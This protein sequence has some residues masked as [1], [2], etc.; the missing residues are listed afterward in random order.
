M[1][2]SCLEVEAPT[3]AIKEMV[4]SSTCNKAIQH[5][6]GGTEDRSREIQSNSK[7]FKIRASE[8]RQTH[9]PELK[10]FK[11][12]WYQEESKGPQVASNRARKKEWYD[13]LFYEMQGGTTKRMYKEVR[14]FKKSFFGFDMRKRARY[15][16]IRSR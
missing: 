8:E 1:S 13:R 4:T 3:E 2:R 9:K 11:K 5:L 7:A 6:K 10:I 15:K 14:P 12:L 16:H